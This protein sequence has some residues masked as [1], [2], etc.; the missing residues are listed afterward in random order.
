MIGSEQQH[1]RISVLDVGQG[2]AILIESPAGGKVL[3][4]GGLAGGD[5]DAG[6][7]ILVP[8]LK[9][10]G[11]TRLDAVILTHAHSDHIGG[12]GAVLE[13]LNVERL[14]VATDSAP[15]MTAVRTFKTARA[16][17]TAVELTYRGLVVPMERSI[18]LY[19]LHPRKD[20]SRWRTLNNISIV[21]KLVYGQSS[22]LFAGDIEEGVEKELVRLYGSFLKSDLLKVPHHG[23]T[24]SSSEIFL[25]AVRPSEAA[26]SVGWRNR[27]YHPSPGVVRELWV[28]GIRTGRT[29]RSGAL[30]Y[31]SDGSRVLRVTWQ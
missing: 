7:R 21:C 17:G 2:D 3:I 12:I 31:S 11:I 16:M 20:A 15:T 1:L 10:R 23:S 14:I 8:F 18:R 4:D 25:D 13:A 24:T 19:V 9:R 30:I 29:D 27:F 22:V 6:E 28:R 26:I 5:Y